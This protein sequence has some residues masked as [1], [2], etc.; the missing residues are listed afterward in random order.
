MTLQLKYLYNM[1]SISN[2]MQLMLHSEGR[3]D[4]GRNMLRLVCR[5]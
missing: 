1:M 4:L 5:C 2:S 3:L